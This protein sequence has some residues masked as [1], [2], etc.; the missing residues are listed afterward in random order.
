MNILKAE[1]VLQFLMAN[2]R[3][4]YRVAAA[5]SEASVA[6]CISGTVFSDSDS[7]VRDL[8]S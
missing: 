7:D 4:F 5:F 2:G 1:K 3:M 6:V 8:V